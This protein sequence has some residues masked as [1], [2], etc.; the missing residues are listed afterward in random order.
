MLKNP[1]PNLVA[2]QIAAINKTKYQLTQ[3]SKFKK[4]KQGTDQ[5]NNA[6][7][8]CCVDYCST[9]TSNEVGEEITNTYKCGQK[10]LSTLEFWNLKKA[11]KQTSSSPKLVV[12]GL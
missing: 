11:V 4:M 9:T 5:A 2:V 1:R 10:Q 7:Q 12:T 8:I 3:H 6:E